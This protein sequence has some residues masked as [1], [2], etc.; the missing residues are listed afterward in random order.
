MAG[1]AQ[2]RGGHA[3]ARLSQERE[4]KL[5]THV[6][7]VPGGVTLPPP[8]RSPSSADFLQDFNAER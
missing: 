2:P 6:H 8:G 4:G 1:V 7:A 3:A 5:C